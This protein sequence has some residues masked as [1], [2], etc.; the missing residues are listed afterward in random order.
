M[1]KFIK[2]I[3]LNYKSKKI[4]N[5]YIKNIK[6]KI[7]QCDI[8]SLSSSQEK[9]IQRYYKKLIGK[10]VPTYWHKYFYSRN[11]FFSVKY[12]P[13]SIYQADIIYRLNNY[14]FRHAYVDKAIYDIYFPDICR[15][16]TIIKNINGYYYDSENAISETQAFDMCRNVP[17]AVIKPT[18]EG[19]WGEGVR[20]FSCE[21]GI[22]KDDGS[23]LSK[24]LCSYGKNFIVQ[25]KVEQHPDMS[26]LNP[27]SLNTLRVLS[28]RRQNEVVILYTI[29]RIGRKGKNVDNE[30]AGGINADIDLSSGRIIDCAYGTPKEKKIYKTD[31]GTLL[32]NYQIP[33]LNKVL[34]TVR[35][36]H[37]RLPYFNLIGWDFAVNQNSEPVLIE[38]NR[39]PDLS[40]TAHGPAFGD[41]SEEILLSLREKINTRY[42]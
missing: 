10:N 17:I 22:V 41:Y 2:S 30:T 37:I 18:L 8:V 29:I 5:I 34:D 16:K 20:L 12:I 24:L 31:N 42:K 32:K 21:N 6:S 38:W 4:E 23:D 14:P 40:Q 11:G 28:Y 33:A 1:K 36:L 26:Q 15:P 3:L 7:K 19:M 39:A 27:S 35:D 13:T 9:E 25:E